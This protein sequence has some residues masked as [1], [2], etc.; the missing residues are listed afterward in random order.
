MYRGPASS[1]LRAP[2]SQAGGTE[3][4][5]PGTASQAG[6]NSSSHLGSSASV[7]AAWP[8]PGLAQLASGVDSHTVD[9]LH[10]SE[11]EPVL[12]AR[13]ARLEAARTG[14]AAAGG[15]KR[16]ESLLAAAA[17]WLHLG[18]LEGYCEIM[19]EL[20]QWDRA[21]AVAPAIGLE[22][23]QELVRARA[24]DLAEAGASVET[25]APLLVASQ[26]IPRLQVRARSLARARVPLLRCRRT[27]PARQF[28]FHRLVFPSVHSPP[29]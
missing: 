5:S 7:S 21:L 6:H 11:V 23:W 9:M 19:R 15:L 16:E 8:P 17:L 20:G 13:A 28:S 4:R 14:R 18:N 25:L 12:A 22:Y 26:Q 1:R 10:V 24:E 3:A 29:P 2:P 27:I